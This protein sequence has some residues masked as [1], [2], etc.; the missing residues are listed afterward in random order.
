V[1]RKTDNH[2]GILLV[3]KPTG[4]TSHDV[5]DRVRRLCA[6]RSVGHAGTLDPAAEGLLVLLLGK[7]T[8][9]GR[10]LTEHD[11]EYRGEIHL[12]FESTTYDA[13]GV[14]PTSEQR[15]VPVLNAETLE[16]V[17]DS[18]RGTIR[19][20]VPAYSAV[21]VE[22]ERLYKRSR[23]GEAIE[24]TPERTVTIHNLE[25]ESH[26]KDRISLKI[27]C[28]KGT[29]IRSLAHGIGQHLGCGGYLAALCRTRVG[30]FE[31]DQ[32]A[33]LD[34][35]QQTADSGELDSLLISIDNAL[36]F[37]SLTVEDRFCRLLA[38]G[39]RPQGKDIAAI[40]GEFGTGDTVLLKDRRGSVLAIGT[41]T[42]ASTN[43]AASPVGEIVKYDRVLR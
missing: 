21:K 39:V 1:A 29:Y 28:T 12:G 5:V 20:K 35:L 34:Q 18:F 3:N 8:R 24:D 33:T 23:K 2:H 10:F 16:P 40:D 7:A 36:D 42:V 30:Q 32:A 6:Q 17:F 4:M 43:L 19:Q 22:G 27:S 11:K 26:T 13:E 37:G 31:L 25:L 15:P 41:A 14:D 38:D 9:V